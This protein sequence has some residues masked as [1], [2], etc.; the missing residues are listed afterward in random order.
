M[1]D[2]GVYAFTLKEAFWEALGED[3]GLHHREL[4]SLVGGWHM[5]EPGVPPLMETSF[6]V[7]AGQ[8]SLRLSGL[9][10]LPSLT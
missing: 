10:N 4:C 2:M 7:D 9:A 8:L 6:Q 1:L 3:S 5:L